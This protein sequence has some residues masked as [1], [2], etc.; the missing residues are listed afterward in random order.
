MKC[1][2]RMISFIIDILI[3]VDPLMAGHEVVLSM[4]K[5]CMPR[6]M[7]VLDSTSQRT[8]FASMPSADKNGVLWTQWPTIARQSQICYYVQ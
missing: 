7:V 5:R 8:S 3:S 4:M 1:D 6:G 2:H